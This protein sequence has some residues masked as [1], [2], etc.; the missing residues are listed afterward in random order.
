MTR[1]FLIRHAEAEGNLCR[2]MNGQTNSAITANGLAQIRALEQRFASETIDVVY[3][4]DLIRT[5]TTARAVAD[6]RQLLIQ[7][8]PRFRE[9]FMGRWEGLTFGYLYTFEPETMA[10]FSHDQRKW[11][12]EGAET[13]TEY[14]ERFLS[15]LREVAQKHE[16]KTIA[17]FSHAMVLRGVLKVLFEDQARQMLEHP[18][19][20]TG[21]SLIEWDGKQFQPVYLNDN[22]HLCPEISTLTRQRYLTAEGTKLD[23]SLW[24]C[25]ANEGREAVLALQAYSGEWNLAN[26]TLAM[27]H[28]IPVGYVEVQRSA[29]EKNAS[30]IEKF[31]LAPEF[32]HFR[33]AHQLLGSVM[34]QARSH[35]ALRLILGEDPDLEQW[36]SFW[37]EAEFLPRDDG[38][39]EKNIDLYRHA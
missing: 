34:Y 22:T 9:V 31:Y 19:D 36:Q 23:Y 17:I 26:G 38:R 27:F 35:G 32:L 7:P 30:C 8:D 5:M 24:F 3:A 4:S 14:T 10:I 1:I 18:C 29:E 6:P 15:G 11:Y 13:F 33:Y 39:L 37:A 20:N 12:V 16:G 25:P 28:E 2:F 21:V